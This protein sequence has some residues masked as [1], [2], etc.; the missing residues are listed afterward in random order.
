MAEG[1]EPTGGVIQGSWREGLGAFRPR[2]NGLKGIG[3]RVLDVKGFK[4]TGLEG[5][6]MR[7]LDVK[8]FEPAGGE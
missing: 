6:D 5:L 7:D 8:G 3:M 4:P 2:V 1:L